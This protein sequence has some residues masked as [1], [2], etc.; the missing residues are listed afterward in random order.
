MVVRVSEAPRAV[1]A[2]FIIYLT[3]IRRCTWHPF[4]VISKCQ[5]V[6]M[7]I[8]RGFGGAAMKLFTKDIGKSERS[9][10]QSKVEGVSSVRRSTERY[11]RRC[12]K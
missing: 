10:S 8:M 2:T 12:K 4:P 3:S 7:F 11:Q 6:P 9:I 1:Q 5:E